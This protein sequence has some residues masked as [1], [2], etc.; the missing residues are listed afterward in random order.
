[1]VPLPKLHAFVN[2]DATE[3]R[4]HSAASTGVTSHLLAT[5]YTPFCVGYHCIWRGAELVKRYTLGKARLQADSHLEIWMGHGVL[6][7][8]ICHCG[9]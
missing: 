1:M 3:S 2:L 8:T 6:R 5:R 4:L 9:T 7:L